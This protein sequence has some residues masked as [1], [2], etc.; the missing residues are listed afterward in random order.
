MDQILMFLSDVDTVDGKPCLKT[1]SQVMLERLKTNRIQSKLPDKNIRKYE[2]NWEANG[3]D[4]EKHEEHREYINDFCSGFAEDVRWLILE[5]RRNLEKKAAKYGK[6]LGPLLSEVHHHL[7]FCNTKCEIFYGREDEMKSV[8]KY[9]QNDSSW[10]KKPF[11]LYASSGSGKTA[12]MAMLAKMTKNWLG[13]ES[14]V[15][16]R[17]L[18]TSADSST[19]IKTLASLCQQICIVY[20]MK[21]E[22]DKTHQ[23]GHL[24]KYFHHL[25]MTVQLKGGKQ[26][27]LVIFLDSLDQLSPGDH[28]HNMLW[29][30]KLCPRGVSII[31]ST[32]PDLYDCLPNLQ[33]HLGS[34]AATYLKLQP[35][36]VD[37]CNDI[38]EKYLI[39]KHRTV[40]KKQH[41]FII[42][43]FMKYPSPLFLKL[44]LDEACTWRSH[45][46]VSEI[47]LAKSV[48][49]AILNLLE[50][51]EVRYGKTFIRFALGYFTV[52]RNGLSDIELE[53]VL[54]CNDEVLN[55]VYQYHDPPVKG[56]VRIP[57]LLWSRVR[58]DI[59]DYTVE[60]Q[61]DGKATSYW[62]HRQFIEA[63]E[64]RYASGDQV[65]SLHADLAKIYLAEDGIK[66]TVHLTKRKMVVEN[67]DRQ[68]ANQPLLPANLRMIHS[69]TYHLIHAGDLDGLKRDA[70]CH[71]KYLECFIR[72]NSVQELVQVITDAIQEK[73]DEEL[74]VVR[75]CLRFNEKTISSD[76]SAMPVQIW[77]QISSLGSEYPHIQRL[78]KQCHEWME[79][80][81]KPMLKPVIPCLP[82]STGELKSYIEGATRVLDKSLDNMLMVVEFWDDGDKMPMCKVF[83]METF[84][85]ISKL[86]KFEPEKG[87][88]VNACRISPDKT[89]VF[90]LTNTNLHVYDLQTG[91]ELFHSGGLNINNNGLLNLCID[92]SEDNK[93]IIFAGKERLCLSFDVGKSA[94]VPDFDL[95][96]HK[97]IKFADSVSTLDVRLAANLESFSSIHIVDVK[98]K[99]TGAVVC[100]DRQ[101]KLQKSVHTTQSPIDKNLIIFTSSELLIFATQ[102]G[103]IGCFSL[104]TEK[105]KMANL[106]SKD[107]PQ[108]V[109]FSYHDDSELLAYCTSDNILALWNPTSNELLS[110]FVIDNT[111]KMSSVVWLNDEHC[112]TGDIKGRMKLWNLPT[113]DEK[114][115]KLA[116]GKRVTQLLTSVDSY[117]V[118]SYGDDNQIKLWD[119]E[120][121][122]SEPQTDNQKPVNDSDPNHRQTKSDTPQL[123]NANAQSLDLSTNGKFLVTSSVD[124][125]PNLWDVETGNF[126][127]GLHSNSGFSKI[128]FCKNDE[129][130]MGISCVSKCLGFWKTESGD[131]ITIRSDFIKKRDC[132]DFALSKNKSWFANLNVHEGALKVGIFDLEA[133]AVTNQ[134][135]IEGFYKTLHSLRLDSTEQFLAFLYNSET[136]SSGCR[137]HYLKAVDLDAEKPGKELLVCKDEFGRT[138][139]SANSVVQC[140]SLS[141]YNDHGMLLGCYGV[142]PTWNIKKETATM[143]RFPYNHQW[144]KHSTANYFNKRSTEKNASRVSTSLD[145]SPVTAIAVSRCGDFVVTAADD[146][147]VILWLTPLAQAGV[148]RHTKKYLRGHS[149][150][151]SPEILK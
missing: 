40:N 68:V 24:T 91:L 144:L 72:A 132:V 36:S 131:V 149:A 56:I 116:H 19:P 37:I 130:V 120:T 86:A 142:C 8:Q 74:R 109:S 39:T 119:W 151:V 43:A 99:K 89:R 98:G 134:F 18:G 137:K 75:D 88:V 11:V 106:M 73:E 47:K 28:A 122:L 108:V 118:V 14:V 22:P 92:V 48:K 25:L 61:T 104:K 58:N 102:N 97:T 33:K 44:L 64:E 127:R 112:V 148:E 51:L 66:K 5:H 63:V 95:G 78:C 34:D 71:L 114:Y 79:R 55:D 124:A 35:L 76:L 16:I 117:Y 84:S 53:D 27:P 105:F 2:L 70:Y 128:A 147:S 13:K 30:P 82:S 54:S 85:I 65:K 138:M 4:P 80:Y 7:R 12:L 140:Y 6:T 115:S 110:K 46:V 50:Q 101:R 135:A 87:K 15:M 23:I 60:R 133:R 42:D 129:V 26:R 62:Y 103:C 69:L 94:T 139:S 126:V 111:H 150:G 113:G 136:S 83:S 96:D 38:I 45:L 100:W 52:G 67:A 77:G 81:E 107:L 1:E 17:F 143:L 59:S 32:L 41:M 121:V 123:L 31:I 57:T 125:P 3:V 9:L 141:S 21:F 29:L 20:N 146:A 10:D 90:L 145:K 49:E 93:T